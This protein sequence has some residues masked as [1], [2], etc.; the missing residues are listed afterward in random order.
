MN[1]R[2][3]LQGAIAAVVATPIVA[4]GMEQDCLTVLTIEECSERYI[5]PAM[6]QVADSVEK[7]IDSLPQCTL[8]TLRNIQSQANF[9]LLE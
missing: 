4:A 7:Q 9:V 8:R 5:T 6:S 3:F 1:R 2:K